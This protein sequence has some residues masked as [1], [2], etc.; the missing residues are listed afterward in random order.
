MRMLKVVIAAILLI[1]SVSSSH[2]AG[3]PDKEADTVARQLVRTQIGPE[4]LEEIYTQG[5]QAA[6]VNFENQILPALKRPLTANEKQRLLLFWHTRIKEL[7]PY[8]VLEDL[9]VPVVT[10]HLT[11]EEMSEIIRFYDTPAGR[12]LTSVLPA[13][14]REAQSAGEQLGSKMADKKWL[15]ATVEALKAEFPQFF[16]SSDQAPQ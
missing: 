2:A 11:V 5:S 1:A 8:S 4:Y 10:K 7:I 9:L 14:T 6:T 16:A 12:K 3:T 13:L 15:D